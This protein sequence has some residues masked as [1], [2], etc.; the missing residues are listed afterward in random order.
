MHVWAWVATEVVDD[1][2]SYIVKG[3]G[4]LENILSGQRGDWNTTFRV[5]SAR[6]GSTGED[7]ED[8]RQLAA[9][10][11]QLSIRAVETSWAV[12]SVMKRFIPLRYL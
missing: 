4:A 1:D 6:D 8:Y 12:F 7:R 2:V 3:R 10:N 5:Q 9:I 11:A